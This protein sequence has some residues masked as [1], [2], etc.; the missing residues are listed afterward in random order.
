M[1]RW[2]K[3][4]VSEVKKKYWYRWNY[5]ATICNGMCKAAFECHRICGERAL[6]ALNHKATSCPLFLII[7]SFS[8][9]WYVLSWCILVS[10]IIFWWC[11]FISFLW[12]TWIYYR[13][14]SLI[15]QSVDVPSQVSKSQRWLKCDTYIIYIYSQATVTFRRS[16]RK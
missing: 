12:I 15:A 3:K 4:S 11:E 8:L 16:Q 5:S 13:G 1:Y 6:N 9:R 10:R 2:L 14:Q 7:E